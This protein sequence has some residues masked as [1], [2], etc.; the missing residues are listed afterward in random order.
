M[1]H[2]ST[3]LAITAGGATLDSWLRLV[4]YL[5]VFL[6]ALSW[7]RRSLPNVLPTFLVAVGL[8]EAAYG[9]V[10]HSFTDFN[11]AIPANAVVLAWIC[12]TGTGLL[13][14]VREDHR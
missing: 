7:E 11:L 9:L 12:G 2:T 8:F 5:L 13:A 4:C 14:R 10:L 6:V 1:K 3:W